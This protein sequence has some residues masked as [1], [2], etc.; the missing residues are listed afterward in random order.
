MNHPIDSSI[1]YIGIFAKSTSGFYSSDY[2]PLLP[3]FGFFLAGGALG[4]ILYR[5]RRSFFPVRERGVSPWKK[6]VLFIGRNSLVFYVLH[7]PL[8]YGLLMV[9]GMVFIK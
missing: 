1:Y 7:Q 4:P 9:A 2:F 8:V 3:W 6:P 5:N